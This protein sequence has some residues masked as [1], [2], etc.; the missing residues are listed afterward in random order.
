MNE[1]YRKL[2]ESVNEERLKNMTMDLVKISSPT[3]DSDKVSEFFANYMASLGLQPHLEQVS[4]KKG[5]P[6]VLTLLK[7]EGLGPRLTLIGHL[8]TVPTMGHP[9]PYYKD[10]I[11]YGRG[12]VDMKYGVAAMG[13]VAR[14]LIQNGVKLNGELMI[15]T[16]SAHEVPGG[17]CEGL[18]EMIENKV[19]GDAVISTEG[20]KDYIPI[21]AK[22]MCTYEIQITRSGKIIHEQVPAEIPNPILVANKLLNGMQK[23][24]VTW[25]E[26]QYSYIGSQTIFVGILE[27]GDFYNRLTNSCRIVGTVRFGPEKD[28]DGIENELKNLIIDIQKKVDSR[29]KIDLSLTKVGLGYSINK[30]EPV[31]KSLKEAYKEVNGKTMDY[32]GMLFSGD[33]AKIICFAN[34]PAVYYGVGFE[35]AH[36]E[37]ERVALSNVMEITKV[38]LITVLKFLGYKKQD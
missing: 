8:D 1:K 18:Y 13:E 36:S 19:L 37:L 38:L 32:G 2:V 16:H 20:P 17:Q 12:A 5:I 26:K 4:K 14:V 11:I 34:I 9:A 25:S 35:S 30:D 24:N 21:I 28:F 22:G 31:I 29:I 27:G 15:A 33:A 23:L 7:G 10:G 3:G 6:N